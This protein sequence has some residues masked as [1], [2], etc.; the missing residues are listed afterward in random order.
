LADLNPKT[1]GFLGK[2]KTNEAPV[3]SQYPEIVT[4]IV[5]GEIN[6]EHLSISQSLDIISYHLID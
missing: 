4:L 6:G 3:V 1:L 5:L 2:H